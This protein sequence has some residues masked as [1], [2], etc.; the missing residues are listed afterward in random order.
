MVFYLNNKLRTYHQKKT[1]LTTKN[2]TPYQGGLLLTSFV[3]AENYLN[4][5][6][7]WSIT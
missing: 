1:N 2:C 6:A 3:V 7:G 4:E 5:V